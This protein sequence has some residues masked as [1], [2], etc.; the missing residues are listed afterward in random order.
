MVKQ[1]ISVKEYALIVRFCK[2]IGL[3]TGEL[4]VLRDKDT[5]KIYIVDA[6]N[7]PGGPPLEFTPEEL[8][9][10][11]QLQADAF[12]KAFFPPQKKNRR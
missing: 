11:L 2:E 9:T 5:G 4:D 6:N 8:E 7:T 12:A 3:D 1:V 10:V